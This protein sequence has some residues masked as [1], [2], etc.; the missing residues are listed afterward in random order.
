MDLYYYCSYDGSPVGFRIG[1]V[2][3]SSQETKM[4]E[5][6][7]EHIEPFIRRCFENGLVRSAFG[8]IPSNEVLKKKYFLLKKKLVGKK[9]SC[10]YYMNIALVDN[11]WD[12]FNSLMQNSDNETTLA[13]A[14]MDSIQQHKDDDFGYKV[15]T[16]KLSEILSIGYAGICNSNDKR[17]Q[18]VQ[19]DDV[20]FTT[21]STEKPDVYVLK[22]GLGIA[23]GS[24][25]DQIKIFKES[26]KVFRF[27]KKRSAST[28][29]QIIPVLAIVAIL[30]V[31]I[32]LII[33]MN[34]R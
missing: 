25:E 12:R 5:L 20:F 10:N 26:G 14:V 17:M 11:E 3:V 16:G 9:D 1:K 4:Q 23:Q 2:D 27:E 22:S 30:G 32:A 18:S 34:K 31:I 15:D 28:W 21:L 7:G 8:K 13:E 6:S 29:K 24:D 33:A 19:N